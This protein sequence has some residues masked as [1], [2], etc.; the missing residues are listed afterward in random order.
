MKNKAHH[1]SKSVT[2]FAC[3]A[4]STVRGRQGKFFQDRFTHRCKLIYLKCDDKTGSYQDE[5]PHCFHKESAK[6]FSID[7]VRSVPKYLLRNNALYRYGLGIPT[8]NAL[9]RGVWS[10]RRTTR[11]SQRHIHFTNS[12]DILKRHAKAP[13][14]ARP[15]YPMSTDQARPMQCRSK[16][17]QAAKLRGK[18]NATAPILFLLLVVEL[19]G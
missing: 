14:S 16:Q 13:M 1:S 10:S 4:T 19:F 15:N 12:N 11:A 7:S 17:K 18:A 6:N 9:K 5:E 3:V 8:S 2:F